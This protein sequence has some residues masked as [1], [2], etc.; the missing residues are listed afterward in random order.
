MLDLSKIDTPAKAEEGVEIEL[1]YPPGK[2]CGWFLTIRGELSPSVKQ[3]QLS[4]GNRNRLKDFRE[5]RKGKGEGPEPMT[6]EDLEFG[7]RAAALRIISMREIVFAGDLLACNEATSY[8]LVRRHPPWADH[9]LEASA[10]VSLFTNR[11]PPT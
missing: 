2:P 1:E 4:V 5:K 3:W 10:D 8:D 11:S 7:L 9:I 6:Q